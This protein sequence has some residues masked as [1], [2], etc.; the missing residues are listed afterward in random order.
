[1]VIK[2]NYFIFL[3]DTKLYH[4]SLKYVNDTGRS[5]MKPWCINKVR[6]K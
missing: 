5:F 3:V 6:D 1:M 2:G 4:I